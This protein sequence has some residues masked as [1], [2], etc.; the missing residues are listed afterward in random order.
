VATKQLAEL[1]APIFSV[2]ISSPK[3][4]NRKGGSPPPPPMATLLRRSATP[5][6]QLLLPRHLAAAGSAPASSRA[7]SRYYP[8]DDSAR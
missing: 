3:S 1:R 7:F 4:D 8:R 6:R 5:V 2:P